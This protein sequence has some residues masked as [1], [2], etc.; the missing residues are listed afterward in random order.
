MFFF[1]DCVPFSLFLCKLFKQ[2]QKKQEPSE[3][4]SEGIADL[5]EDNM[6]FKLKLDLNFDEIL[7][8]FK[9]DGSNT[10]KEQLMQDIEKHLKVHLRKQDCK[11]IK[12]CNVEKGSVI[13]TLCIAVLVVWC[14]LSFGASIG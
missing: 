5:T 14:L 7:S 2:N 10:A 4:V 11:D 6:Y 8:K 12:I 1:K 3:K 9:N 13:I